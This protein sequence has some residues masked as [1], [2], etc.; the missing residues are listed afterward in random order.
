MFEQ[1]AEQ[2]DDNY[3]KESNWR[4]EKSRP[5]QWVAS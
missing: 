3:G 5:I 1:S 4:M 2:K